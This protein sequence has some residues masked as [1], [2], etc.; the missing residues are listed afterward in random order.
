[1]RWNGHDEVSVRWRIEEKA[2]E[3]DTDTRDNGGFKNSW[4]RAFRRSNRV[5]AALGS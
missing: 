3:E 1:M 5:D 2:R 4:L